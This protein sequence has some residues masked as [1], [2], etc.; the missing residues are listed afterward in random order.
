MLSTLAE[1]EFA[2]MANQQKYGTDEFWD[3]YLNQAF[4]FYTIKLVRVRQEQ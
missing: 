4:V 3:D 2:E 1:R